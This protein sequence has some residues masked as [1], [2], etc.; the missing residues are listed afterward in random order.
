VRQLSNALV[1]FKDLDKATKTNI[2]SWK[3]WAKQVGVSNKKAL[4]FFSSVD[5]NVNSI[6][7]LGNHI[8]ELG[9]TGQRVALTF[10]NIA[11]K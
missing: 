7:D 6:D 5:N 11:V 10:K 4:Q 9:T 3:E 2:Q 1:A 8:E